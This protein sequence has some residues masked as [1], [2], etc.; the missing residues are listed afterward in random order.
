LC[1]WNKQPRGEVAVSKEM[2]LVRTLQGITTVMFALPHSL[3]NHK[4]KAFMQNI[5]VHHPTVDRLDQK[6]I[7]NDEIQ[8]TMREL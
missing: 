4:Q 1:D 3:S 7:K 8:R 6:R 2:L 5:T